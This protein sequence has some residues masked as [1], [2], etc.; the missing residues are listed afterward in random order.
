[1]RCFEKEGGEERKGGGGRRRK[2]EG[3]GAR[4]EGG[5]TRKEVEEG[6]GRGERTTYKSKRVIFQ[7]LQNIRSKDDGQICSGHFVNLR[8]F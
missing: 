6:G 3:R 5:G 7:G 2:E 1:M 8:K 4:K